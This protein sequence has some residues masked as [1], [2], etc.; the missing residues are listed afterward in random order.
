MFWACLLEL[1][2]NCVEV[3]CAIIRV[4]VW[5]CR[6]VVYVFVLYLFVLGVF[7]IVNV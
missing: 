3:L 6:S 7:I 2:C 5:F 1:M 4:K